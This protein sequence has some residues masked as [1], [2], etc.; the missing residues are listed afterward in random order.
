[1]SETTGY[2]A[3]DDPG[4]NEAKVGIGDQQETGR[5][6]ERID[7]QARSE[8][9]EQQIEVT[10]LEVVLGLLTKVKAWVN[11]IPHPNDVVKKIATLKK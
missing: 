5:T 6:Q 4:T 10:F 8:L 11:E 1:M 3:V 7:Y 9:L 2:V